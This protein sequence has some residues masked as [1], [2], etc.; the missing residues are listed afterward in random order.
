[1]KR[2]LFHVEEDTVVRRT[3]DNFQPPKQVSPPI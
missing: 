1:M 3:A 2:V